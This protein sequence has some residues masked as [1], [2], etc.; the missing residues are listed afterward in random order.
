M[1]TST[2]RGNPFRPGD[3]QRPPYLAGRE[4]EQNQIREI[5][6]DMADGASPAANMVMYG[7]RGMGKTVLLHWLKDELRGYKKPRIFHKKSNQVRTCSTTANKLA[8]PAKMW[9]FLLSEETLAERVLGGETTAGVKA[10]T[11]AADIVSAEAFIAKTWKEK[12]PTD[13][14]LLNALISQCKKNPL[15]ALVD[16]AHT[17][18]PGLCRSLLNLSQKVREKAPFLLVLA[19]TPGLAHFLNTVG[20][21]FVE[22]STKMGI[23]RL[24]VQATA[25]AIVKPLNEHGIEI[26]ADA[27]EDVVED[28]Q[29]YPYFIQLWGAALWD[30]AKQKDLQK[31]TAQEI[32]EVETKVE[33]IRSNFYGERRETL[34]DLGL[35]P[36][37]VAIAT[38][39]QD[40]ETTT[41]DRLIE[42]IAD[43]S[44]T[45]QSVNE[46]LRTLVRHEFIWKP[47][48]TDLYEAGIPSLMTYV[49]DKQREHVQETSPAARA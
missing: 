16:E 49:L 20:A 24:D 29:H 42:I 27:L 6:A 47:P 5:L 34:S 17:M 30:L 7:P 18:E 1:M 33:K 13:G 40:T 31:L 11:S 10:G 36:A 37:A 32:A 46:H 23:A 4:N 28:S 3:G 14:V 9:T 26:D 8:T 45:T 39:F 41:M 38:L 44:H 2:R 48:D 43:N 12:E 25:D 19:G 22:R 35:L 21:S 15:V